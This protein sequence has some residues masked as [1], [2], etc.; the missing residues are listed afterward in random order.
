MNGRDIDWETLNA[1][2]DGEL[3]AEHAAEVARA[4]ADEPE[5]ARQVSMIS[6][7]KAVTAASAE[8]MPRIDLPHPAR[9]QWPRIAAGVAVLFVAGAAGI[10]ALFPAAQE[11]AWLAD[12][13]ADHAEWAAT[14]AIGDI[15]ALD[16]RSYLAGLR[17]LGPAPFLPDLTSARL[18]RESV[19]YIAGGNRQAGAIH[20]GY[21][22][23]RG[24]RISLWI[25]I[26]DKTGFGPLTRHESGAG[27]SFSWHAGGLRYVVL[28]SGMDAGRFALIA[29]AAHKASRARAIPD[30]QT[31]TALA[32]SRKTSPPCKG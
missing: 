29:G 26:T 32:H 11:E 22:G 27:P 3:D 31:R 20:T 23:T 12:A 4:A 10:F 18:R 24:C 15:E 21:V 14:L 7:L 19:R 6:Q 1:Y 13:R 16:A 5:I 25:T 8:P 17:R 28:S 30:D 9:P 2:V